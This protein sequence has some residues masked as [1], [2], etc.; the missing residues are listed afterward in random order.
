LGLSN[1][2]SRLSA[3]A[4]GIQIAITRIGAPDPQPIKNT[5]GHSE[6]PPT[7]YGQGLAAIIRLEEYDHE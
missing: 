5:D 6:W 7:G 1:R 4:H 2:D 3:N